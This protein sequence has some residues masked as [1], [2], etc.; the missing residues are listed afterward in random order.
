MFKKGD[1][2][3][4]DFILLPW[5]DGIETTDENVQYVRQDSVFNP[6]KITATKGTVVEDEYI[7]KVLAVDNAAEFKLSGGRNRIVVIVD[8]MRSLNGISVQEFAGGKWTDYAFQK[9]N[10][11]GYQIIYK[12]DGTYSY[13]FVVEM[14]NNG[15]E[16]VFKVTA[17]Q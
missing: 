13:A 16:R 2:I 3:N 15:K 6:I 8:G 4:I 9:N 12:E 17:K 11:D 7:P 10:Y 5:G 14:D 1:Y